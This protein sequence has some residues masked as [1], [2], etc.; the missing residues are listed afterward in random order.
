[1]TPGSVPVKLSYPVF[2]LQAFIYKNRTKKNGCASIDKRMRIRFKSDTVP[3]LDM[4]GW[5]LYR[6][7]L[8]YSNLEYCGVEQHF[9]VQ[10]ISKS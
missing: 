2:F 1:M 8:G 5:I 6:V 9:W 10:S 7:L 3:F 4:C